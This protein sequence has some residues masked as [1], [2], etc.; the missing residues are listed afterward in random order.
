MTTATQ[1][2]TLKAAMGSYGHT[3]AIKSGAISPRGVRFDQ[4]EVAPIINAFR[5]M[6]R[7]LEFD[8]CEMAITTYLCA[9]AEN[10]PFTAIPV[11]LVRAFHHGTTMYNVKSGVTK[12]KDLEGKKVG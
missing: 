9:R 3:N 5:R 12:P 4:V 2:L 10:K 6:C 7:Q 11:F 1:T 8:A